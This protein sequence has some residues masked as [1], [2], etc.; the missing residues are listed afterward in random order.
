M[1]KTRQQRRVRRIVKRSAR[2]PVAKVDSSG[3][4]ITVYASA[5]EAARAN[6][7]SYQA[8][9]DR[10]NGKVQKPYALDGFTYQFHVEKKKAALV[11]AEK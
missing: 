3:N 6:F 9:L 2:R 4:V 11:A 7:M 10:C 1:S 8:V 5:R